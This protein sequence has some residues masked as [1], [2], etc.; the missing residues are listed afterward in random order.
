MNRNK[1]ACHCRNITYGKIADAVSSG[2][3]SY[4]AVQELTGCGRSCGKCQEFIRCLVR[5]LLEE[6]KKGA[7]REC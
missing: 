5:E 3:A 4:E 6:Q 2:A 7:E 1:L